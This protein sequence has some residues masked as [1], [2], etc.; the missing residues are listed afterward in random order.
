MPVL[1]YMLLGGIRALSF[2]GSTRDNYDNLPELQILMAKK[3][4][5]TYIYNDKEIIQTT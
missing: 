2:L 4:T 1:G 5:N 3:I